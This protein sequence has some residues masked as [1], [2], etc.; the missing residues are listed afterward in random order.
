V[1]K[2]THKG[3]KEQECKVVEGKEEAVKNNSLDL[4]ESALFK[5]RYNC[6]TP[7]QMCVRENN[8]E[9]RENLKS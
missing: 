4:V 1:P 8:C 6:V 2:N 5:K 7:S 9:E 3:E